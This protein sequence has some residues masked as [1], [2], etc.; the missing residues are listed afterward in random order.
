[1]T[2]RRFER[3]TMIVGCGV[4]AAVVLAITWLVTL[5]VVLFR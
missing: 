4:L 3:I 2:N 5:C 1:M